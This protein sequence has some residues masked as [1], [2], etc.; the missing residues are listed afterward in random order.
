MKSLSRQGA[1]LF[2]VLK[3]TIILWLSCHSKTRLLSCL[4]H[5]ELQSLAPPSAFSFLHVM[6]NSWNQ[7]C[8]VIKSLNALIRVPGQGS[9]DEQLLDILDNDLYSI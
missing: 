9:S 4:Q 2:C 6:A 1:L 8:G 5:G 7:F 3:S